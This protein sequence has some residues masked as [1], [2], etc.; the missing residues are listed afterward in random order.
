MVG[1]NKS[2]GALHLG[3]MKYRMFYKSYGALRLWC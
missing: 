1:F 2:Y 3:H